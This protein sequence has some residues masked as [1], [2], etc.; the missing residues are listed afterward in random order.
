MAEAHTNLKKD[1]LKRIN[2]G[3]NYLVI[4]SNSQGAFKNR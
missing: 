4:E 1:D 2:A 3:G